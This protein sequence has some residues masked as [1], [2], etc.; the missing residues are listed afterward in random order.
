MR[1]LGGMPKNHLLNA[2]SCNK[3]M[4]VGKMDGEGGFRDGKVRR[5]G[6]RTLAERG[7]TDVWEG[8]EDGSRNQGLP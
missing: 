2:S 6:V 5:Q 8:Y 3:K 1:Q 7:A 4:G